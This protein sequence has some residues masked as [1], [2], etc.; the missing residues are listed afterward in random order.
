MT[1]TNIIRASGIYQIQSIFNEKRYIGSTIN[2]K[3]RRKDHFKDLEEGRNNRYLQMHVRKYG[4]ADLIFSILE[5][6]PKEKLIER[7]QYWMD[8]LQPKFNICPIAG[9][10]LGVKFSDVACRENG[11]R[12]RKFWLD[13]EYRE[14]QNLSHKGF[15]PSEKSKRKTSETMKR[16]FR[17]REH[18]NKGFHHSD[19]SKKKIGIGQEGRSKSEETKRRMAN[20][21]LG[22]SVSQETRDKI[23][24]TKRRNKAA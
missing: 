12:V 19:V 21:K 24:E 10:C 20:S 5:F 8:K 23:S 15:K 14:R 4:V 2:L 13:P 1:R 6:C 11:E 9:S 16:L 17:E 3:S 7:E 22:H 18:W